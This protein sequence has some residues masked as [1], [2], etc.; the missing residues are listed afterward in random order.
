MEMPRE[1]RQVLTP[2]GARTVVGLFDRFDD[3][4]AAAGALRD[5]GFPVADISV[6]A[7]PPGTP[8]QVKADET[9]SQV[10]SST[11]AI[12]GAVLGAL[13][14]LAIPGVGPVLAVGPLATALA[15]A[16]GGATIGGFLGSFLG[17][18]VPTEHARQYEAHVR[19][20]GVFV[21][22]NVKDAEAAQ[23]ARDVLG[24]AGARDTNDYQ[25]GL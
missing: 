22:I 18:D 9:A 19:E 20:G 3:A 7:R 17:L 1:E 2:I 21:A 11:G 25:T 10:T 15:G 12:S 13:A 6:V 8:P 4:D 5:A 16:V 24:A 14:A 23:R